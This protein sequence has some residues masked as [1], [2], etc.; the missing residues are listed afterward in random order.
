MVNFRYMTVLIMLIS[1]AGTSIGQEKYWYKSFSGTIDKYPVILHLHKADHKISGYYYYNKT[2]KPISLNGDDT[3]IAGKIRLQ[4]WSPD[5]ESDNELFT[6]KIQGDSLTGLWSRSAG[7]AA[8][9]VPVRAV[10]SN[11]LSPAFDFVFTSGSEKL[12]PKLAES[13]TAS[14][15]AA[16]AWP[17]GNSPAA[18]TLKK[19]ISKG[20][21][22]RNTPAD[23]GPSLLAD[24]KSFLAGYLAENKNEPDSEIVNFISGYTQDVSNRVEV[25][26]HSPTILT[27]SH[28]NY[29]Y[30]G[31]AHGNYGTT[32]ICINPG[33]GKAYTLGMVLSAAGQIQLNKLVEKNFRKDRKLAATDPLT[34]G[35]LFDDKIEAN[36]NFYLTGAGITFSYMPYEIGPYAMGEVEVFIPYSDFGVG[37]LNPSFKK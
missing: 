17:K 36:S 5:S 25:V 11:S 10:A 16:I 23:I 29:A 32:Y 4:S 1:V 9:G 26:F 15:E 3:T 27:L 14:Y 19:L 20:L 28:L 13:P 24:K 37:G 2:Q 31:G 33:T 35:G 12:R 34:E 30:T 6:L 22:L 8:A 7:S 21:G 18:L